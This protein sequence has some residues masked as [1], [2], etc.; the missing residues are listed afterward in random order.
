MKQEFFRASLTFK[1]KVKR[2]RKTQNN[3]I[4]LGKFSYDNDGQEQAIK[5]A[6]Q[7]QAENIKELASDLT[8]LLN[9]V[10]VDGIFET[11]VMFSD[12]NKR[13]NL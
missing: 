3:F 10:T 12:K 5:T 11:F 4:Q 2:Q 13:V 9:H 7:W 8:L 6:K 1:G